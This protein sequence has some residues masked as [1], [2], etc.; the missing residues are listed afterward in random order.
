MCI[1]NQDAPNRLQGYVHST[2]ASKA[3]RNRIRQGVSDLFDTC[4]AGTHAEVSVQEARF[5]FP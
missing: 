5:A 2:D 3:R 1:F 4:S